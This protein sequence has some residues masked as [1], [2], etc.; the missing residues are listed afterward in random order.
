MAIREIKR[1]AGG[2]TE[3]WQRARGGEKCFLSFAQL[4]TLLFATCEC[5]LRQT[6]LISEAQAGRPPS[7]INSGQS[8]FLACRSSP[9]HQ[10]PYFFIYLTALLKS[11]ISLGGNSFFPV[12]LFVQLFL[13]GFQSRSLS[14]LPCVTAFYFVLLFCYLYSGAT[15]TLMPLLISIICLFRLLLSVV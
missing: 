1:Q 14:V 11:L 2:M 9:R 13:S 3:T 12:F 5:V 4:I 15:A 6:R 8:C 7:H 10:P